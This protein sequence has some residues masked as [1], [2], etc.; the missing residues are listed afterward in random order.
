MRITLVQTDILWGEIEANTT[1]VEQLLKQA[2]E[3]DLYILPEMWSTGFCPDPRE[4]AEDE[5]T[6][7]QRMLRLAQITCS[8]VSGSLMVKET[9]G[10]SV[11]FYNRHY[12]AQHN[13][14]TSHYDKRHLFGYGGENE[15][16]TP[17]SRRTV[18]ECCGWRWLLQTCYDLRF[19]VWSRYRGDYDGII[20][21]ANWPSRRRNAWEALLRARAIENQCVVCGVNRVGNDPK[22]SYSGGSMII[23]EHGKLLAKCNDDEEGYAS[24]NVDITSL[25]EYRNRFTVL[26][27][28]DKYEFIY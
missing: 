15:T 8:N 23:D 27:D 28:R 22:C 10:K 5:Q 7:A 2:P 24:C 13:N 26:D 25:N 14:G 16:F 19:P 6:A 3:S 18:V 9:S 11:R 1:H 12:L 20:Y 17:G 4:M 21:I